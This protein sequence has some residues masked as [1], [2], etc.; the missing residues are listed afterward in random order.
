MNTLNL[1]ELAKQGNPKAI[2]DLMN[3]TLQP[4][5]I[6]ICK[7]A[8]KDECLQLLL[9][10]EK[11]KDK[12]KI[13]NFIQT[14][15]TELSVKSIK[16][17]KILNRRKGSSETTW[18]EKISIKSESKLDSQPTATINQ[19]QSSS[20]I[21]KN[22]QFRQTAKIDNPYNSQK[23]VKAQS[24][25]GRISLKEC[26][27]IIISPIIIIISPIIII[28]HILWVAAMLAPVLLIIIYHILWI[29]AMLAPLILIFFLFSL[30]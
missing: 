8:I 17:I 28:C 30:L 10:S 14:K 7:S 4:Q 5:G 11:I 29:A 3:S 23:T 1:D 2:A 6:R 18:Y 13:V 12:D 15:M 25:N 26:F 22:Y 19:S 16:E 27:Y 9:E 20:S 24:K 21:Q